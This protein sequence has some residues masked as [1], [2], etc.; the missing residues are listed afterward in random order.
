MGSEDLRSAQP[1]VPLTGKL[2][3]CALALGQPTFKSANPKAVV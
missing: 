2:F 3:V 1:V